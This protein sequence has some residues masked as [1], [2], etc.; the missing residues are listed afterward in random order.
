MDWK[1]KLEQQS[2]KEEKQRIIEKAAKE[3]EQ[4]RAEDEKRKLFELDSCPLITSQS[5]ATEHWTG[6]KYKITLVQ[7][8]KTHW[9]KI[10]KHTGSKYKNTLVARNK[11]GRPSETTLIDY[12]EFVVGELDVECFASGIDSFVA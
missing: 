9:F 11:K 1:E 2:T 8:T 7:N 5:S 12:T 10:Q 4:L 6:S 3:S